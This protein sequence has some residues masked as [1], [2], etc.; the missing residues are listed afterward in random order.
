MIYSI[1]YK[2]KLPKVKGC[3]VEFEEPIVTK[4]HNPPPRHY[5]EDVKPRQDH[6]KQLKEQ[7]KAD[8]VAK[9]QAIQEQ[10]RLR[11]MTLFMNPAY[12]GITE[13]PTK[14]SIEN[15]HLVNNRGRQKQHSLSPKKFA[16]AFNTPPKGQSFS[17]EDCVAPVQSDKGIVPS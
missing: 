15:L 1:L 16:S 12:T 17:W 5:E 13:R 4:K 6:W 7:I 9:Q 11:R 2:Q 8:K 10:E 3:L 14:P